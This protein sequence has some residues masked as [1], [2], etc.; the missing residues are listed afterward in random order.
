MNK[1]KIKILTFI[2]PKWKSVFDI[3]GTNGI[4]LLCHLKSNFSHL[5][6]QK[7]Q[8]N[9]NVTKGLMCTSSLEPEKKLN[10]LLHP[11]PFSTHRLELLG[12]VC[13]LNPSL[14]NNPNEK[15]LKTVLYEPKYS[16]M[17]I[18]IRTRKY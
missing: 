15:F 7:F 2:R 11:N 17:N 6:E 8:Q 16:I 3:N 12:T 18:V 9:L 14:I 1:S 10:K 13:I 5:N 4:K